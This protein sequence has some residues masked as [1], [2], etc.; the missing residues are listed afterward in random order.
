M[1]AESWIHFTNQQLY[2]G[3]SAPS[4]GRLLPYAKTGAL[5][6]VPLELAVRGI[7][8]ADVSTHGTYTPRSW[9]GG[10]SRVLDPNAYG[11]QFSLWLD[12]IG[13]LVGWILVEENIWNL[14]LNANSPPS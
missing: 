6:N 9:G 12:S 5:N 10:S 13:R 14:D 8:V 11:T 2:P 1:E 3:L 4:A 7:M